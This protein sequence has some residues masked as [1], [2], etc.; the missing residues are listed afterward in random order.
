M[1]IKLLYLK[2]FTLVKYYI[3][4]HVR[5]LSP[6]AYINVYYSMTVVIIEFPVRSI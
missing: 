3:H 4:T 6:C 5:V 1:N 2:N